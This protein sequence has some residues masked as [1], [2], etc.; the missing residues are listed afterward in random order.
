VIAGLLP[1]GPGS[2]G[3]L[4]QG[5][6]ILAV[7]DRKV[8]SR[9]ELYERLWSHRAGDRIALQIYRNNETRTFEIT[10]GDVE[11]FFG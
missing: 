6:V 5:D 2:A 9:R 10:S 11:E 3:G 4:A 8:A 1:D 7:D